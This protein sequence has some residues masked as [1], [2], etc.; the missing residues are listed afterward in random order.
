MRSF[1][2]STLRTGSNALI[3]RP[4]AL[5]A[6]L[7]ALL[8]AG[9]Q[10]AAVPGGRVV[11]VL[12]FDNRSGDPSLNW[13]G[14]SFP[15]TLNKRLESAGFLTISHDDRV[16]AYDHLGLPSDFQPSRA[17]AIRI[18]QQL[19][20]N[21]ILIGSYTLAKSGTATQPGSASAANASSAANTRITIQ[22]RV[23]S[24]NDLILKAP[25]EDSAE[26]DRLFDA[27]NAIAWKTARELDPHF[28]VAEPTFLAA[29][30]AVPL[31]A[32]EDYI[33][34]TNNANPAERLKRLQASVALVP[35]YASALL[36]LGKEQFAQRDYAAAA[37][38]LARVPHNDRTALEAN[39]YLGL[40][41]FNTANYAAAADAFAYVAT[42]LP[43]PEVIN[44]QAVALSR[45]NKDS[46]A[47][48]QRAATADPSD[49]DYHYNLAV[50][51]YRRGD[52]QNAVVEVMEALKLK[53]NDNEAAALK[54]QLATV[55]PGTKMATSEGASFTAAERI[56]RSYSETGFRQA[57]FLMDQMR[58]ARLATLPAAQRAAEYTQQG[59]D[60]LAEGLLPEAEG[61]F[62]SAL[63][64]D[65]NAYEAHAGLAQIRD[66]SGDATQARK[67]AQLSNQLHPNATAWMV[68]ARLD[69]AANQMLNCAE[70]VAHALQLEPGNTAAQAMKVLLQQRGQWVP[71]A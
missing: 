71:T 44:N 38:T 2:L 17:T 11:L 21:F 61:Q 60:Y 39:F 58:S 12:P 24:L 52:T 62:Q 22:A 30:G 20:A 35:T 33:R 14:D 66:A 51:Y 49:E 36:A 4:L 15:D 1:S 42:K 46:V 7:A 32:F 6:C 68:L 54:R 65:P 40:A 63:D 55:V 41:R 13:I 67:Q 18:A 16:Y 69:M 43:L 47:L 25:V 28:N 34:G 59:R 56:R 37:A 29:P 19:D 27:E 64:A 3:F 9:A 57:A 48:F 23:L 50:A 70:D 10:T 53:P 26:L 45:Q 31:A 5:V 8:P